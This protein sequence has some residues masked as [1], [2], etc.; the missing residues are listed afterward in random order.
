LEAL[1][2]PAVAR[3]LDICARALE[4]AGLAK[5]QVKGV[6]LAG[7]STR[8]PLV[9]R[10]V[11]AFFGTTPL[12]DVNPDEVVAVGAALQAEG[13][14]RGS[15]NLLLDVVPLS[16]GLETMGGLVEKLIHRNTPIP[17]AVAQEFTTYRD[18]QNGMVIHVL[19]GEREMVD[20][21]RS[22]AKFDLRGIPAMQAGIARVKVTF[23]VD[24]DGLLS[25]SAREETT[26]TEQAVE[27]KPSY[28]LSDVEMEAM[29][30]A[31][32]QNAKADILARL[33]A[34]A[35]M[36]AERS[37]LELEGAAARDRALL[38]KGEWE[39]FEAQIAALRAV[40]KGD[41]RDLID[42]ETQKLGEISRPFAERRMNKAIEKALQGKK[43]EA[44]DE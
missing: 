4:D 22:L 20:Q 6:V 9:K 38:E 17:V 30:L 40:C 32:M 23:T 41:D 42:F 11:E 24:A 43:V 2:K 16:L 14:T 12:T 28:G 33:L 7:G 8:I 10:E 25:V 27:V 18:G 31:S 21:C 19:Q 44:I 5:E 37:I 15:D 39:A 1:M 3:T 34:E 13:L 36:E 35:R 29:L 26:G